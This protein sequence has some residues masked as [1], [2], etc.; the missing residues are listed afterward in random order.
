MNLAGVLPRTHWRGLSLIALLAVGNIFC[1]ACPFNFVRDIGRRLLPARLSWPRQ[2]RSKWIAIVLL[3]MFFWAYEAFALWDSPRLTALMILAYFGAALLVDG[4]FKGASFCKYVCPIGQYQFIQSLISP[5]EV[6]VRS[7]EVCRSC[8]THDCLR[9]NEKQRGCELELFQPQKTSNMDC[10]FCLDCVHS[11]PHQNVS[12]LMSPPGTQLIRIERR[13]RSLRWFRRL[14]GA[15]LIFLLVFLAFVNAASMSEPAQAWEQAA[16]IKLGLMS[17]Q[18]ILISSYLLTVLVVPLL[19]IG[20]CVW[21]ARVF[22]RSQI[23]WRESVSNFALAFVPLGFSMWLAHFLYHLLTGAHT[24]VPVLQQAANSVGLSVFGQ[25]NWTHAAAMLSFDWLPAF[26]L[27]ML[28]LG[29]LLTLYVAWR[30]ARRLTVTLAR[31]VGMVAPWAALGVL[32]Y[33][34]GIWIIFQPMQMR[35]MMMDGMMIAGKR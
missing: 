11:C 34:A 7:L 24:A 25:P 6:G 32:L 33:S 3:F 23:R 35:G 20:A 4:L 21:L 2:L 26:Q 12:L 27:L 22:G 1:M 8:T 15:V 17:L 18:P 10:T 13:K 9:G 29:L 5:V 30:A 19:L 16:R 31:T 14:D 28:D